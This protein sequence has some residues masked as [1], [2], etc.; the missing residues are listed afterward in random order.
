[1]LVQAKVVLSRQYPWSVILKVKFY[2]ERSNFLKI[3]KNLIE[4]LIFEVLIVSF[5][6][7][8]F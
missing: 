8:Y 3:E 7:D 1:M 5:L 6:V 2:L 4:W